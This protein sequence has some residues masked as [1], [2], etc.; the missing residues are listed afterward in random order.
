MW[1]RINVWVMEPGSASRIDDREGWVFFTADAHEQPFTW[2][3]IAYTSG[4]TTAVPGYANYEVPPGTYVVWAERED[5]GRNTVR[6]H[7]AVVAVHGEPVATV[8]LLPDVKPD[9]PVEPPEP[10]KCRITVDS[11]QGHWAPAG[12]YPTDL[13]ATGTADGCSELRV[14]VRTPNGGKTEGDVTV[15]SDGSWAFTFNNDFDDG[16][17]LI[18]N[19]PAFVTVTCIKDQNCRTKKELIVRCTRPEQ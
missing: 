2:K 11:V 16:S 7:K 6:T 1:S 17:R 3:G 19:E 18:C 14:T 5:D 4:I 9:H 8:R 13:K 15:A 12:G 10:H